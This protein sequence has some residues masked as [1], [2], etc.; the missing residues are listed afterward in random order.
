MSL[1]DRHTVMLIPCAACVLKRKK[2]REIAPHGR[3]YRCLWYCLVL[4]ASQTA[5][6]SI[7]GTSLPVSCARL[8]VFNSAYYWPNVL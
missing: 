1:N 8:S 2:G 6:T 5:G 3:F 4:I 7:F